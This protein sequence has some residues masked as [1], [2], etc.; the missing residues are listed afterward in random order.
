MKKKQSEQKIEIYFNFIGNYELPQ[1]ELSEEEKQKLE[2]E[3]KNL[4]LLH[5]DREAIKSSLESKE[6]KN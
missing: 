6:K 4:A 3:E 2:E 1:A 5:A